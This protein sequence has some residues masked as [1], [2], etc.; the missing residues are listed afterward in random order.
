[1]LFNL[2]TNSH[3]INYSYGLKYSILVIGGKINGENLL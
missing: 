2:F 3:S 1:M